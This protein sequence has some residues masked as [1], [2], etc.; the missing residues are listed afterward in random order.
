MSV[1]RE[2]IAEVRLTPPSSV[3]PWLLPADLNLQ[4][5]SSLSQRNL[6]S[7]AVAMAP[8]KEA[9]GLDN[10]AFDV[11]ARI[12]LR[13]IHT[14]VK[15]LAVFRY[16]YFILHARNKLRGEKTAFTLCGRELFCSLVP[17]QMDEEIKDEL[18]AKEE[19]QRG[20]SRAPAED[21]N[22]LA[23]CVTDVPPWYL[24]I[25]LSIQVCACVD[26]V[27]CSWLL[28]GHY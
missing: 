25:V 9:R 16:S 5:S 24:C 26:V 20:G 15:Y 7:P 11:S 21:K 18:K 19:Q 1:I 6:D 8:T 10:L 23:Y 14:P 13:K 28:P 12:Y 2:T 22:K 4:Q 3:D 17:L 27:G